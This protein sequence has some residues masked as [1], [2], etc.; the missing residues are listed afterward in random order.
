MLQGRR[1][2]QLAVINREDFSVKARRKR[3]QE[4]QKTASVSVERNEDKELFEKLR[5]VRKRI[6][7]EHQ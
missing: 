4:E 3:Q 7:D 2:V 6:A 1:A 5:E